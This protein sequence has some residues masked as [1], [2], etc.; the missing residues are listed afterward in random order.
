MRKAELFGTDGAIAI[1]ICAQN[2]V[3]NVTHSEYVHVGDFGQLESH[4]CIVAFNPV[5]SVVHAIAV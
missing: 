1:T 4:T 5:T 2:E 3:E